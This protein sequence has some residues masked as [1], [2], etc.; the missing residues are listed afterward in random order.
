MLTAQGNKENVSCYFNQV[1]AHWT[2]HYWTLFLIFLAP[3][4]CFLVTG[5][6]KKKILFFF[7]QD[8]YLPSNDPR[9]VLLI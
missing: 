7:P 8:I 1:E 6:T 5:E 3:E 9:A 2:L 4:F